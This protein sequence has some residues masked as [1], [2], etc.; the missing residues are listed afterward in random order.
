MVSRAE[1]TL[2]RGLTAG[3][4]GGS[5]P[6]TVSRGPFTVKS[7][8]H[9]FPDHDAEY[10]DEWIFKR[11][12]GGQ[13]IARAGGDTVT[14]VFA[15]G[16]VSDDILSG[17]GITHEDVIGYFRTKLSE[18]SGHTRLHQAVVPEPDGNWQY[19]Y[20]ILR[21][22]PALPMTVGLETVRYGETVVFVHV[23]LVTPVA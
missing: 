1:K 14:R 15:G 3:Y 21:S 16:V 10:L 23:F 8:H 7:S 5:K 20:D 4:A 2:T 13:E 9:S 6:E 17:L 11:T 19:R 12:G 22:Y 18:V